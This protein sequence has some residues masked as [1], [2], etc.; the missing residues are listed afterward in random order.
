MPD[1]KVVLISRPPHT[2]EALK[3]LLEKS[4]YH[5][6]GTDQ[7]NLMKPSAYLINAPDE[8]IE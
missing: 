5:I 7:F 3:T 1:K 2:P 8:L 6:L 4:S